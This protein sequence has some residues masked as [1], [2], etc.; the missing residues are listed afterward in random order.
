MSHLKSGGY[1]LAFFFIVLGI[2]FLLHNL[3]I[4]DAGDWWPLIPIAIGI[5]ILW[6]NYSWHRRVSEWSE[7]FR[8]VVGETHLGKKG[9]EFKDT[10]VEHGI[11]E[12]CIDLSEAIFSPG[13]HTL[14]VYNSIGKI[15]VLVPANLPVSAKGSVTLGSVSIFDRKSDGFSAELSFTSPDYDTAQ[16]RLKIKM[17]TFMGEATLKNI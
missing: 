16:T 15:E 3:H 14:N 11:G 5:A 4:V 13:E 9:W 7:G 17:N 10:T 12:V 1:L 2:I 8:R 6:C